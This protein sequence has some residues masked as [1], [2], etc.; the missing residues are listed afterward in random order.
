MP[1]N[2]CH[3]SSPLELVHSLF[4]KRHAK[5]K[6]CASRGIWGNCS[7][8]NDLRLTDCQA[9]DKLLQ[10]ISRLIGKVP[11]TWKQDMT[12]LQRMVGDKS[13]RIYRSH[14]SRAR[15]RHCLSV[16]GI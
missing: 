8:D 14:A 7:S 1:F 9:S 13:L 12:F 2:E 6:T 3:F 15:C 4:Y 5:R 16:N 10:A 11:P